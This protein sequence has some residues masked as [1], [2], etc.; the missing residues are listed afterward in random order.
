MSAACSA[1][2]SPKLA[3]LIVTLRCTRRSVSPATYGA[4][5]AISAAPFLDGCGQL[6][7]TQGSGCTLSVKA[8]GQLPSCTITN[9]GSCA[10]SLLATLAAPAVRSWR[11][12]ASTT[13]PSVDTAHIRKSCGLFCTGFL[14]QKAQSLQCSNFG[15][16]FSNFRNCAARPSPHGAVG[17]PSDRVAPCSCLPSRWRIKTFD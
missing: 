17:Q 14:H 13:W 2:A 5:V 4:I 10:R 1:S 12:W 8:R 6:A 9:L 7:L 15:A 16:K 3:S 11:T